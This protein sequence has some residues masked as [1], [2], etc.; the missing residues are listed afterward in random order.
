[1]EGGRDLSEPNRSPGVDPMDWVEHARNHAMLPAIRKIFFYL[2]KWMD[3]NESGVGP[4]E[5]FFSLLATV[6]I[7]ASV[8]IPWYLRQKAAKKNK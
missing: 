2:P 5:I 1:M 7:C 4:S 8:Y 3:G 6:I